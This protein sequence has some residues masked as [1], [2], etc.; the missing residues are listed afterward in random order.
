[1]LRHA[2]VW[3]A[4]DL[5]A[6]NHGLTPSGLARR[7]GLDPTAFNKSKR[8]AKD[9]RQRWPSTESLAKVLA[10]T[11]A[12][13]GELVALLGGEQAAGLARRIPVIGYAEAG[14]QGYFDDAGYPTGEG[15][16]E[17][18]FPDIGDSQAYGLEISGGS[19]MPLYR[20]GDVIVVSPAAAIRRGDRVVVKTLSGEVMAKQLIRQSALKVELMSI[21]PDHADRT[22]DTKEIAWMSRIIWASQ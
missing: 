2:D 16:D 22:L 1:M 7:A 13:M 15:W 12:T 21:S 8:I 10:A 4:L 5:L 9:G 3:R 14:A 17:L 6:Q 11:G 18:L 19:M 20:D